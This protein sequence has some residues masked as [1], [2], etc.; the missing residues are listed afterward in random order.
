MGHLARL[1]G[2]QQEH[3]YFVLGHHPVAF[4]LVFNLVIAFGESGWSLEDDFGALT[5]FCLLVD[6]G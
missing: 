4:E 5:G 6:S 3:L 2:S 1:S